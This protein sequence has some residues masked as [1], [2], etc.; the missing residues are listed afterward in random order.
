MAAIIEAHVK[1]K[2]QPG[3]SRSFED[4]KRLA[5]KRKN[6]SDKTQPTT[7]GLHVFAFDSDPSLA[8]EKI[9]FSLWI[10]MPL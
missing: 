7:L 9:P 10:S 8:K 5:T 2:T 4:M 6:D 1:A 3:V